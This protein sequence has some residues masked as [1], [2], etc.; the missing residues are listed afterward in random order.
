MCCTAVDVCDDLLL[1]HLICVAGALCWLAGCR[2]L[3][4][5]SRHAASHLQRTLKH[6]SPKLAARCSSVARPL[7]AGC[8]F[9]Q[10]MRPG[11]RIVSSHD[12]HQ[13]DRIRSTC[14][15]LWPAHIS[16]RPTNVYCVC[17]VPPPQCTQCIVQSCP[18]PINQKRRAHYFTAAQIT[19]V[20]PRL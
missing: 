14:V 20:T 2:Q 5:Q 3:C 8:G 18:Q 16:L 4:T 11:R 19:A 17:L 1:C 12:H 7:L 9:V 10:R 13:R 6:T 15:Q